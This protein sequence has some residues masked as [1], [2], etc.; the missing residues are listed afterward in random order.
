MPFTITAPQLLLDGHLAGPGA[1][2]VDGGRIEAIRRG[3]GFPADVVLAD[4]VLTAGMVDL[5]VN[6][7]VG[8]DLAAAEDTGWARVAQHL[9]R[10]GVTAF[11]P[12][13]I[14]APLMRLRAA[15]AATAS[16]R[17]RGAG[18]PRARVLG[19]HLEG[20]FLSPVRP[21]A[22]AA[23]HLRAPDAA[24]L[25]A[26]LH[27]AAEAPAIVT[28]APELPGALEAI[29]RLAG[30]GVA[31]ALGHSDATAAQAHAAAGAGARL[32]THLFNAMRPLHHREPGLVGAALTDQ[33]LVSGLVVDGVHVADDVVALA[34]AAAPGRIALVSDAV[35]A[36]GMAPGPFRV[37]PVEA[38]AAADG[39]PRLDD[40]TLAGSAL[41]LDEAVRRAVAVGVDRAVALTA[42]TAVPAAAL[43][44][45]AVHGTLSPGAAADLVWWSDGL[46]VRRVWIG[47]DPVELPSSSTP[48]TAKET[49]WR[50]SP[51]IM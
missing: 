50:P 27:G 31:V 47:G 35:A 38:H 51:S 41:H 21:G 10:H 25:D 24:A 11:C 13:F 37:G 15:L 23:Q 36:A 4:G 40:G 44:L 16:A 1:V 17:A 20:P 22:H 28:L 2:V 43:G 14:T 30:A 9:A 42:A 33:R 45:A 46:D 8:V 5:Q 7:A 3:T 32:T 48:T 19:A 34:F 26:L 6:G 39:P 29:A 12:T 18:R 49:A